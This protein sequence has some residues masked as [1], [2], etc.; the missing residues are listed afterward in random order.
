MN[1]CGTCNMW[2]EHSHDYN[3]G[4]SRATITTTDAVAEKDELTVMCDK[5]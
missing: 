2:P 5:S 4:S 1:G 3:C